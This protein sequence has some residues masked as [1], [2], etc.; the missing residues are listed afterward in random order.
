MIQKTIRDHGGVPYSV[1]EGAEQQTEWNDRTVY[2][3]DGYNSIAELGA[4]VAPMKV[5]TDL[6]TITQA[7]DLDTIETNSNASKV[8]TDLVTITDRKSVV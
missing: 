3:V 5:K 2:G 8:K 7:V 4:K 1:V 6:I